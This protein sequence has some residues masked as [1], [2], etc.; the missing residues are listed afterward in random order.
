MQ[1]QER[2]TTGGRQ[3]G[4]AVIKGRRASAGRDDG[5][6]VGDAARVERLDRAVVGRHDGDSS[7][8]GHLGSVSF[9]V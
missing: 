6:A 5:Q 7:S 1:D 2:G 4:T 9:V 3:P 8:L